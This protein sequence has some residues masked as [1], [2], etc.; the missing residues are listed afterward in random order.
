[1]SSFLIIG[2]GRFG[3][4]VATELYELRHDVLVVDDD[5]DNIS[6]IIDKVTNVIIGDARDEAVLRSLG[7]QNFDCV[8]VAIGDEIEDSVLTTIMLKEMGAKMIV[9]KAQN[10]WHA[11][12]LTQL[13]ADRVIRPESD[14]GK[15]V[16]HSLA[17]RNIINY[18]EISPEYGIIEIN[19]PALWI[20][21]SILSCNI[22]KKHGVT[23]IAVRSALT[24]KTVFSPDADVILGEGDTLTV[25]GSKRDLDKIGSLKTD[26]NA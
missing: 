8:V 10:D 17:Q 13:G 22:R 11:K 2:I 6:G 7:V 23:V 24:G 16:A 20:S 14:M 5:E 15:R 1:M 19:T 25:I 21:K 3:G 12:I 4:A 26:R 9:C 18:L